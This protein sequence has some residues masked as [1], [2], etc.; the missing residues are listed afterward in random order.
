MA[1]GSA[2]QG[3]SLPEGLQDAFVESLLEKENLHRSCS[4]RQFI[5]IILTKSPPGLTWSI[6]KC[7]SLSRKLW[8]N[9]MY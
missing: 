2:C 6:G 4:Y 3:K 5:T 1:C 7:I 8:D 9:K